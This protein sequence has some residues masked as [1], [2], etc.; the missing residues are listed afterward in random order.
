MQTMLMTAIVVGLAV[1][2]AV[3]VHH[4]VAKLFVLPF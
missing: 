1:L 4:A 2:M 3:T